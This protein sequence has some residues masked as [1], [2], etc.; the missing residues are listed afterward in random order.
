MKKIGILTCLKSNDV[1]ARVGC[2]NSFYERKDFFQD[3]PADTRLAA[4]MTCNGC[5][6]VNGTLPREDTG[7]L[8]K[9]DRLAA[10]GISTVH[11]GV[12]RMQGNRECDRITAICKLLEDRGIAVVRG[13]HREN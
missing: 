3:Y 8:E 2:L 4:V 10:E 12:C 5:A 11:V 13:T 6:E 9:A 1:C 7:I